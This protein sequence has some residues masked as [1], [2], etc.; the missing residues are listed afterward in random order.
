[1]TQNQALEVMLSGANVFLTG[2]PGS[3]KTFLLNKFIE[4]AKKKGKRVATT[5][6]T[7]IAATHIDGTTIHSWAGIGI[8]QKL[9][10]QDY[11]KI[12]RQKSTLTRY[13]SA[14][15]L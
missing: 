7:G 5:A 10:T 8:S 3:G 9:S 4:L 11:L 12:L 2:P 15:I 14:D 6:T 1:M 13:R